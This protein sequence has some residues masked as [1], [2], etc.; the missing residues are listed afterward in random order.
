MNGTVQ[1]RNIGFAYSNTVQIE[2]ITE[3]YTE[4][5]TMEYVAGL[6]MQ[7]AMDP[8]TEAT[9]INEILQS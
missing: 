7:L 1:F 5:Y 2:A 6:L 3:L 8:V 4:K 9:Q